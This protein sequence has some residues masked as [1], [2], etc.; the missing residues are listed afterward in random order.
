M[1]VD[2]RMW[3]I[4]SY[5][6]LLT[7]TLFNFIHSLPNYVEST[8]NSNRKIIILHPF[9]ISVDYWKHQKSITIVSQFQENSISC[10]DLS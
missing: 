10:I 8:N 1:D 4:L 6:E 2:A 3:R 7:V 9:S 5:N